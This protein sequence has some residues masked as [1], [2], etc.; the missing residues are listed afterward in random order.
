MQSEFCADS[1][2]KYLP[3]GFDRLIFFEETDST[4]EFCKREALNSGTFVI[5]ASQSG[6]KGRSG[7]KFESKEGGIFPSLFLRP[8]I[9]SERLMCITGMAAVAALG[10][11][12]DAAGVKCAIKWTNYI[13]LNGKKLGGILTEL[14]FDGGAPAVIIGIGINANNRGADFAWD[15]ENKACSLFTELGHKTD[16]SALTASLVKHF[17][18]LAADLEAGNIASYI[19]EYRRNCQTI[20]REVTL[21]WREGKSE[22]SQLGEHTQG[23]ASDIDDTFGLI[24]QYPDGKSEILRS[25]EV[26]VR[27]QTGYIN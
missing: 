18:R 19:E 21:L 4:N 5:A 9:P 1:I 25:G 2:K 7:R 26:S 6:G 24:I 11:L 15:S 27:G 10:A 16:L 13:I 22:F 20:G 14:C 3:E 17:D 12:E 23:F 8:N